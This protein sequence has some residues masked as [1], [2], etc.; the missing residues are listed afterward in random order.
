MSKNLKTVTKRDIVSSL[1]ERFGEKIMLTDSR[2]R[3]RMKDTVR[4]KCMVHGDFIV[5]ARTACGRSVVICP[6]CKIDMYVNPINHRKRV[7]NIRTV[8]YADI[9]MLDNETNK[10]L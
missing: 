4:L 7:R 2:H 8:M 6:K 1:S 10:E 3:Y 9:Y 5:T